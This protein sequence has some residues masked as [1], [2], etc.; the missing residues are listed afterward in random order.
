MPKKALA[1][2]NVV[3]NAVTAPLFRG[4]ARASKR[5][6][7]FGAKMKTIGRSISMSFTLPFAMIGAAGAKLAIDFE[8]SMTKI[9]TLVGTSAEAV[10]KLGWKHKYTF[11]TMLNEMIDYWIGE[12]NNE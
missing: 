8:Q 12:L 10:N 6:M 7:A 1:S 3:I 9:T 2:L 11:E 5:L 4:L